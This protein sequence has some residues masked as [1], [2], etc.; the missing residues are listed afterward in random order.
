MMSVVP[1]TC[2]SSEAGRA[3][4]ARLTTTMKDEKRMRPSRAEAMRESRQV[5]DSGHMRL[6]TVASGSRHSALLLSP[7]QLL[8]GQRLGE[9]HDLCRAEADRV[10]GG[11]DLGVF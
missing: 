6:L 5:Q 9:P 8:A 7:H 4:S 10:A 11:E 2:A 3:A 1:P